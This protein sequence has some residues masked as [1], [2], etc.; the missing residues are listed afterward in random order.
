MITTIITP[1]AIFVLLIWVILLQ[2]RTNAN[3]TYMSEFNLIQSN[4]IRMCNQMASDINFLID[5]G[6]SKPSSNDFLK[7]MTPYLD[8]LMKI[9]KGEDSEIEDLQRGENQSHSLAD[10]IKIEQQQKT[11]DELLDLV[12]QKDDEILKLKTKLNE[13]E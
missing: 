4:L 6:A 2:I 3:S 10:A 7:S 8:K 5:K 11:I 1:I 13:Y 9:A 12:K